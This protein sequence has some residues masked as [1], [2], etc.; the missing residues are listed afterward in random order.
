[1]KPDI[2][3]SIVTALRRAG[4]TP[5]QLAVEVSGKVSRSQVY[6]YLSGASDLGTDKANHLL[7]ALGLKLIEK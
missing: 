6:D 5:N 2:R 7:A 1:M 4:W 3:H